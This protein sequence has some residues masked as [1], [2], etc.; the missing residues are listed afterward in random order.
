MI[1]HMTVAQAADELTSASVQRLAKAI[2]KE[3][4]VNV[5]QVA[6][7]LHDGL[8]FINDTVRE[9]AEK[10]PPDQLE[11][12]GAKLVSM[13]REILKTGGLA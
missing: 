12:L 10:W 8:E 4:P 7:S 2:T 1:Q 5:E 9:A 11:T 6:W 13:G 3:Q